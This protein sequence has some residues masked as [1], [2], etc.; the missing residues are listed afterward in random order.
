MKASDLFV[1]ALENEGVQFISVL[2][3]GP[4][5]SPLGK[6]FKGIPLCRV[7]VTQL[8]HLVIRTPAG[9]L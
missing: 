2:T 3:M 8:R 5:L 4:T 7:V 9:L 6:T 1:Q